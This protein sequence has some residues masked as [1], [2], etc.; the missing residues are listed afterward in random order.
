MKPVIAFY[1]AHELDQ[2][3]FRER[4]SD[5][6]EL[7]MTDADLTAETV[8][9]AAAATVVSTHVTSKVSAELM[10]QLPNL[11]HVA[12]R[13]TGY[14]NVDLAYCK[15]HGITVSS[16]PSY[17]DETVAEYAIM[18]LL[19][20]SRK[21]LPAVHSVAE[22]VTVPQQLTGRDLAGKT[23][24]IIGTGRIG[25]HAATI[26]RGFGMNIIAYDPFPNAAAAQAVGYQYVT[27]DELFAQ[28]DCITLHAPATPDTQHILGA[29]AFKQVKSG[30]IIV[31]TARGTLIDTPALIDALNAGR[32]G[33][34]G[35]DVLEG[36][37]FLQ[38]GPELK[39]LDEQ[40]L[41]PKTKQVLAID[42]LTK[43]PN[44]LITNHNAYNSAEALDRIRQTTTDNLTAWLAGTAQNLVKL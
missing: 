36:E 14:D 43:L 1:D 15:D 28:A 13:S 32:V 19:A 18:L 10:A 38:T 35:L 5:K 37:E 12:C 27:L 41:D 33:G 29:E 44:V 3:F 8:G 40:E 26:A 42:I 7:L 34:A 2:A 30:V 6:F 4:L 21:L 31:N 22:G 9:Q 17:G 39:L 11:K 23:L 20:V 16:V 24:G 25:R